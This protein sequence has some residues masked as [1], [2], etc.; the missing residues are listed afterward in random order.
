MPRRA[1]LRCM[2]SV[3]ITSMSQKERVQLKSTMS[4][5]RSESG[6]TMVSHFNKAAV[7]KRFEIL[8]INLTV[9]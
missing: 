4:L 9:K 3:P 2:R 5:M 7:H 1:A 8:M 6:Q